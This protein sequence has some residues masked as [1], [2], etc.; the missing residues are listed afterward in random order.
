MHT[1]KTFYFKRAWLPNGWADNVK[2][3]IGSDGTI[4]KVEKSVSDHPP[5]RFTG[6]VIPGMP[7]IHSHAFQ[8][9]MAGLA[10]HQT[11]AADSFWTWRETMYRFANRVSPQDLYH[12]ASQLYV[13]MLQAGFTSVAEF[14][15]IHHQPDGAPYPAPEEAGLALLRAA[16]DVGIGITLLPV[17]YMRSGFSARSVN[18][19]QRRFANSLDSY[20]YLFDQLRKHCDKHPLQQLG[21]ALHSLRAV[22]TQAISEVL[23]EIERR[24]PGCPIHIHIAEQ[25]LEVEDC[26]ESLG[27]RPVEWLLSNH[28]VDNRWCLIHATHLSQQEIQMLAHSG[29]VAGLCPTTEANLGDGIFP[30]FE[31]LSEGGS[32]AVG[33]DSNISVSLIEE[34]R[35]LEYGQR[36]ARR[37]RNICVNDQ[38]Q[39]TGTNLYTECLAG[40]ALALGQP[41][42]RIEAGYR[43]DI[44]V[45]DEQTPLLANTA[46]DS[47]LDTFIFSGNRNLVRKVMVGGEWKVIDFNHPDAVEITGN[48]IDAVKRLKGAG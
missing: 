27:Q 43:A 10:E 48:Y 25:I 2:L 16:A 21:L 26:I 8:R 23:T 30:L 17:L 34:L 32:I 3:E 37:Q 24:A 6:T 46:D 20:L 41:V 19:E 28:K 5:E 33:S 35:W 12:I 47:L 18:H 29:A 9:A 4:R 45:L 42:G 22:P 11:S 14:H 7:N 44:L 36:L 31:Y 38:E 15:Y 13:E 1:D 39:H 40:G